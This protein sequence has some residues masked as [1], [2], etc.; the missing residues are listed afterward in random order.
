MAGIGASSC[1]QGVRL[2]FGELL[3]DGALLSFILLERSPKLLDFAGLTHAVYRAMARRVLARSDLA[4]PTCTS[5]GRMT[6]G[7]LGP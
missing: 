4:R 7:C 3:D 2:R 1:G 6:A 5:E